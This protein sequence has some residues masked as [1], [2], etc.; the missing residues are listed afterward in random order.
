MEGKLYPAVS[1]DINM[2]GCRISAKFWD[3]PKK[4]FMFQGCL[5]SPATLEQPEFSAGERSLPAR[6][7]TGWDSDDIVLEEGDPSE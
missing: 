3:R 6:P 4:D 1:V 2:I 7:E 5:T